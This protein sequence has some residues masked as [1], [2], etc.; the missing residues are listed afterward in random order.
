MTRPSSSLLKIPVKK[1]L[2]TDHLGN[3]VPLGDPIGVGG[4]GRVFEVTK[5]P[6]C[7]AK[8]YHKTPLSGLQLTKL[9]AMLKIGAKELA[10]IAAWPQKL[11]LDAQNDQPCGIVMTRVTDARELHELYGA[12]TRA[13]HYPHA[14]WHHLVLAARNA[15]AAF[16]ALHT[17]N[18]V[19][20]DVNQG[21]LLVDEE[22]CVRFI[23]CDS[24]QIQ[25]G[26][27]VLPCLVGTP[28]FT[29]P[30][31][32][33]QRLS[34]VVRTPQHDAFG[35]ALLVF[36]LL[37]VGRHPFAGRFRGEGDMHIERAISEGR[38]AF[39]KYRNQTQMDP[40]PASLSLTDLPPQIAEM[41][42]AALR[43]DPAAGQQRPS[44]RQWVTALENLLK[45]RRECDIDSSHIYYNGAPE[46]PWCRIEA[47]GGPA[48]FINQALVGGSMQSRLEAYDRCVAQVEDIFFPDLARKTVRVPAM[49][50]IKKAEKGF[51]MRGADWIAVGVPLAA[52]LCLGGAFYWPVLAGGAVVSLAVAATLW[53]HPGAKARRSTSA[54]YLERI[55]D[56]SDKVETTGA[57]VMA[58]H[59]EREAEFDTYAAVVNT[60][61]ER[62][63][64]DAEDLET[65]VKQLRFE[66]REDYL[67]SLEIRQYRR[68]IPG[69]QRG[70]IAILQSYGVETANDCEGHLL[71]G[72]PSIP[73]ELII[74]LTQW[75]EA[76]LD[77]FAFQ[78]EAGV[79]EREVEIDR[80]EAAARFKI[81]QARKVLNGA[82]RLRAMAHQGGKALQQDLHV[83]ERLAE[84]FRELTRE[85]QDFQATRSLLERKLNQNLAT[86][87]GAGLVAPLVGVLLWLLLR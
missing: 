27:K 23:D 47:N 40:P 42:E 76:R 4:E 7:A 19:I 56:L 9:K 81:S 87:C 60:G 59:R 2:V 26:K 13:R 25:A 68:K 55:D 70:H 6:D 86:V 16:E 77:Q 38:F 1:P 64:A 36:H 21:N 33:S 18:V 29:P 46:C 44:A 22:M 53:L 84:Q 82:T 83:F 74:E 24:F 51:P 72:I 85:Y 35:L 3:V 37:F 52:A 43:C 31:L 14:Y 8:V 63:S 54:E 80:Q 48:F 41:F 45:N 71:A 62:Y 28:H 50:I 11:L 79:T 5:E 20:G 78:P 58:R 75:R 49:P 65:I 67:R 17:R 69:L 30:E 39:S 57:N 61:R 32:Q 73:P 15:A 10:P 12:S 34:E 66:Q